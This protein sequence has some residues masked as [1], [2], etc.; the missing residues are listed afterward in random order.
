MKIVMNFLLL[1]LLLL[2]L[3][4]FMKICFFMTSSLYTTLRGLGLNVFIGVLLIHRVNFE[5]MVQNWTLDANT[6]L[7][8]LDG[9]R[10]AQTRHPHAKSEI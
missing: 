5:Y 7:K 2:F 4:L 6:Q 10:T 3:I 9:L 8:P 1:K